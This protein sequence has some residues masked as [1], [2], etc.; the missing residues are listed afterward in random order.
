MKWYFDAWRKY[1][2][3]SGRSRRKAY[4]MFFLFDMI[5]Y[6][7]FFFID[8][9]MGSEEEVLGSLYTLV[10]IIP[11][12]AVGVRRMHDTGHSGWWIIVPIAN[13][14]FPFFD[15]EQGENKYGPNPKTA[16]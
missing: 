15:S 8:S 11:Y 16:Y 3:F 9:M 7:V 2:K 1:G 6:V 12:F 14:V 4:W 5:F 13:L 10:T